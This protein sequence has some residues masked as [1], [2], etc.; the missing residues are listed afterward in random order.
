MGGLDDCGDNVPKAVSLIQSKI[1]E[2]KTLLSDHRT[3][4]PW[5]Q[6]MDTVQILC[7]FIKAELIGEWFLHLKSVWEMLLYFAA[8]GHNWY[9][10]C[11]YL[12]LQEMLCLEADH[13]GV[14]RNI[15]DG[16]HVTCRSEIYWTG[17]STDL[18]IE[19]ILMRSVKIRGDLTRGRGFSDS[20][21]A[22]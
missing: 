6:Y 11:A 14:Y 18:I 12:Y 9:T 2:E 10:R 20:H 22:Q 5:L 1:A 3:A 13:P 15:C 17:L 19:Q 7:Q 4:Q 21:R 16:H 8:S